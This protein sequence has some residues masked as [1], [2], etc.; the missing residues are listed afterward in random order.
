ML[1]LII[2]LSKV[3]N[4]TRPSKRSI[5]KSANIPKPQ[6]LFKE[7]IDNFD[8]TPWKPRLT[9]KPHAVMPFDKS[10]YLFK[11]ELGINEYLS[12]RQRKRERRRLIKRPR[13]AHPYQAE[14]ESMQYPKEVYSWMEPIPYTDWDEVPPT[15]VDTPEALQEMIKDMRRCTEIAVDLEHHDTR[16]YI[17]LTCLMQ[18]STRDDDYIV[19]TLKLRG[20]LEPL[21]EIFANPRVLKVCFHF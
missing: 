18:L 13:Y 8:S 12:K 5:Q 21:N 9:S 19:D 16:S 4:P 15:W 17:G 1:T 6:L 7:K 3:P 14:I 20:Q 2:G 10:I 11:D